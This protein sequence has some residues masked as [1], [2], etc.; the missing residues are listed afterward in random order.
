MALYA[1]NTDS[2][3][4]FCD[5]M[6][7]KSS[8]CQLHRVRSPVA[9]SLHCTMCIVSLVASVAPAMELMTMSMLAITA[10]Q[11]NVD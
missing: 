11:I 9:L 4:V 2:G 8:C 1:E 10:S 3:I 5:N 7:P 6:E